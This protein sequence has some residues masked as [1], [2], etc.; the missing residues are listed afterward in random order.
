MVF[1]GL[2]FVSWR[3][4]RLQHIPVMIIPGGFVFRFVAD[5]NNAKISKVDDLIE[6]RVC[7]HAPPNQDTLR[8]Y[9]EFQN[10]M[11]LPILVIEKCC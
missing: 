4:N 6:K 9:K 3:V 8:L 1:D 10:P 11:R 7:S 2:H 5:R